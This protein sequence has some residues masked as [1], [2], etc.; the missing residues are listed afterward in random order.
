MTKLTNTTGH[1]IGVTEV[2]MFISMCTVKFREI[3][4][5]ELSTDKN[6]NFLQYTLLTNNRIHLFI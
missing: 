4:V 3:K 2:K 1:V 6:P 5:T